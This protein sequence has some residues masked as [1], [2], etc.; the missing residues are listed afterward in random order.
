MTSLTV[1]TPWLDCPELAPAYW[2]AMNVLTEDDR[3]VVIDNASALPVYTEDAVITNRE[4]K[5]F[6]GA[7]NQ[8]LA[9]AAMEAETDAVAFINNDVQMTS[10]T[11]ADQIRDALRPGRLVGAAMRDGIPVDGK[12]WP[13]LDGWCLAGMTSDLLDL[14]GWDEE[15]EEPSYSGDCDLCFR[16]RQAGLK[17]VAVSVG[18]RHLENHTSRSIDVT[19]LSARNYERYASKVRE[20]LRVAA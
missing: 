3:V 6:S 2:R 14:G 12:T 11:W 9:W 13:Y 7:S 10:T 17:L 19:A 5:G 1:V 18:L 20:A 15:F 8:G 16:A 4:N